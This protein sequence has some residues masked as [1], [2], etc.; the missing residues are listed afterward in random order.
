MKITESVPI[1]LEAKFLM[2]LYME[3]QKPII[4]E[5]CLDWAD[6]LEVDTNA[7]ALYLSLKQA[8]ESN[9]VILSHI[10]YLE[11]QS[12]R[13][14]ERV[15]HCSV[16]D[17][18]C[19]DIYITPVRSEREV[20]MLRMYLNRFFH[21]CLPIRNLNTHPLEIIFFELFMNICQH[22]FDDSGFAFISYDESNHIKFVFSDL[23]IGIAQKIKSFFTDKEFLS[24][25]HAIE[26][27]TQD[28]VSTQTTKHN[29]GRGLNTLI[30]II[31]IYKANLEIIC[32]HGK[33]ITNSNRTI[34]ED[35]MYFY[36][37][38]LISITFEINH[39]N[40]K[41]S[42]YYEEEIDF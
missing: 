5:I 21:S 31:A 29:K 4:S 12:Y 22:S 18:N 6:N 35:L 15:I 14:I 41:E 2:G 30:S 7:I 28:L 25:A 9:N 37:G 24:D 19:K 27:A 8:L 23:G 38:T 1:I 36:Q 11:N 26:Y 40:K 39:L 3:L 10:N 16:E 33:F 42:H 32:N 20:E 34:L 17:N 13:R